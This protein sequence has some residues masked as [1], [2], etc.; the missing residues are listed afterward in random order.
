[1][2]QDKFKSDPQTFAEEVFLV[3]ALLK[4]LPGILNF[5]GDTKRWT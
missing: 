5:L 1:M 3:L 4:F 2:Y